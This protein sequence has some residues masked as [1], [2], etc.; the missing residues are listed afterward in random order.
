M[1][2]SNEIME[3]MV[4]G[5]GL[6]FGIGIPLV[7]TALIKDYVANVASGILIKM[8]SNFQY[9]NSFE[10][11]GRENCRIFNMH[12]TTVE[13]QDMDKDQILTVFNSNFVR[14]KLWR[15]FDRPKNAKYQEED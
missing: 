8:S 13:I 11:E 12:L 10:F 1:D 5:T 4:N 2:I 7:L 6:F 14:A 15:K 9:I 3:S